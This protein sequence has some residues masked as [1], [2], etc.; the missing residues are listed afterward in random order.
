MITGL[1]C[2]LSSVI[3]FVSAVVYIIESDNPSFRFTRGI[4][5]GCAAVYVLTLM[6]NIIMM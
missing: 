3:G 1:I 2:I 4:F 5:I 6:F